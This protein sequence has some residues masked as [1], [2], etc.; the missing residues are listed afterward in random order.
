M[1]QVTGLRHLVLYVL[2]VHQSQAHAESTGYKCGCGQ[3]MASSGSV[4]LV[5]CKDL[6]N[7]RSTAWRRNNQ[8]VPLQVHLSSSACTTSRYCFSYTAVLLILLPFASVPLAVTVRVLPSA[9]RTMWAVVVT[10][11]SFF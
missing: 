1:S 5:L 11:P 6:F 10:L 4:G 9:D 3:P 8:R 2:A 7:V